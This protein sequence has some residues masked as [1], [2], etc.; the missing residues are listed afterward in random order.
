MAVLTLST[1]NVTGQSQVKDPEGG[2]IICP[3]EHSASFPGGSDSLKSFIKKNLTR[4]TDN[5]TGSVFIAFIVE[6]DGTTGDFKV[7]RGLT[8]ESDE[9]ALEVLGNMPTWIP[10]TQDGIPV[11]QRFIVPANLNDGTGPQQNVCVI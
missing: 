2:K 3:V 8:K 10:G 4:P 5:K 6:K 9:K 7:V 1:T 11:R